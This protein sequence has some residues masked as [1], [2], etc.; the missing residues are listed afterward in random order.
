MN[1]AIYLHLHEEDVCARGVYAER[2]DE[3]IA[4]AWFVKEGEYVFF[5]RR[6]PRR[7]Q[8]TLRGARF[9]T[10]GLKNVFGSGDWG[11]AELNKHVRAGSILGEDVAGYGEDVAIVFG[12]EARGDE[13]PRL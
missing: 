11:G 13:C 5:F 7:M 6:A 4:F 9:N 3:C 10:Q 12:G 8:C 2:A 1:E